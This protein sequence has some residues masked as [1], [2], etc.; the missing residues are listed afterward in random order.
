MLQVAG[1]IVPCI[2]AIREKA[3]NLR[4]KI[5]AAVSKASKIYDAWFDR[6]WPQICLAIVVGWMIAL[7][8]GMVVVMT[9]QARLAAQQNN[10]RIQQLTNAERINTIADEQSWVREQKPK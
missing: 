8:I 6:N 5:A 2:D 10:F 7:T 3:A 9:N 1:K 4:K